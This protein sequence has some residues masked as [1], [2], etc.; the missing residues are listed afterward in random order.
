MIVRFRRGLVATTLAVP[1]ILLPVADAGAD[2]V[3]IQTKPVPLDAFDPAIRR[4]GRLEYRGG[5][6][7]SSSDNRFGGLSGL[8]VS[9]DG[10]R[11]T[12]I[13]DRGYWI[14]AVLRYDENGALAG[15]DKATIT[16][17]RDAGGGSLA[18][19]P[20][21]DAEGLAHAEGGSLVL[22]FEMRPKLLVYPRKGGRPVRLDSPPGLKDAAENQGIEALT[23]L[24]DGRLLALT[25]GLETEGGV[26]GW[27]GGNRKSW[28]RVT[29][30]TSG[31]FQPTGAA[32][33]RCGDVL[34][35]ERRILPPG[36]RVRRLEASL[37]AGDAVLDGAEIARFEGTLTFDNMEGI[38]A[39]DDAGE[40]LVYLV[41]DDNYSFLQ[42]TLLLMFR[43]AH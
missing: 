41:S 34:V 40:S 38:D 4:V 26:V 23:R 39:R 12:A 29:W 36:A 31:G 30:L 22:S 2:P 19:S 20:D 43:I 42:R 10:Q 9:A 15:I 24:A 35:L 37:I 17:L 14:G 13:S 21:G 6:Q 33:L 11:L 18:R 16:E 7:L 25:E 1:L 5:L 32:T 27:I 28:S 8:L 3:L